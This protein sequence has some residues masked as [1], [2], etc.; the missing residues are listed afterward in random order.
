[1]EFNRNG[2]WALIATQFQGAFNDNAFKSFVMMIALQSTQDLNQRNL[3]S[4]LIPAVFILPFVI[5]SMHSGSVADRFSKRSVIVYTKL[6]EIF[7][8]VAGIGV[9]MTGNLHAAVA[10]M[11]FM[12]IQSAYFGPSKYGILPELVPEKYLSWA[13]GIMELTTFLAIIL[14]T[15]VGTVF[16][17]KLGAF[18]PVA[19]YILVSLSILGFI[20]S[21]RVPMVPA[22][23]PDKPLGYNPY[24]ELKQNL[25]IARKDRVLWL[26]MWGNG[27][28]WFL[29]GLLYSNIP[30]F[31]TAVLHLNNM[32][33]GSLLVALAMGIGIGS[34]AAGHLSGNK[35][36]YGLIPLGAIFISIFS[37]DLA[38]SVDSEWRA[39][40]ALMIL[41]L[42][43]G[44]FAVP[45]NALI[46][47]RPGHQEKGGI[48]GTAYFL[49]NVG[50]IASSAAFFLLT[51]VLKLSPTQVFLAGALITV[52][53]TAY[54][55]WLLPDALL[56]LLL[57]I[58]SHTLYRVQVV[59]RDN[60]PD[61]GGAMFVANHLSFLDALFVI[62]STDRFVRFIMAEE[63]YNQYWIYPFAR[64]MR[65][66]PIAGDSGL[67]A[68]LKSLR[69]ASQT[70][71]EGDIVCIFAEGQMT[72]TGQ[73]LPFRRGFE[74]IMK[75]VDAPIIPIHLDR[76]WGSIFSFE[77]G[78]YFWKWPRR[79]M[80][81]ITVSFGK[82]MPGNSSAVQVRR[83]IMELA[84]DAFQLRRQE[85]EPL[86]RAV[87]RELRRHF[88][89]FC[90]AD[91]SNPYVSCRAALIKAVVLAE[92]LQGVWA[93]QD[94]VGIWLPPSSAGACLNLAALLGGKVPVNLNFTAGP[95]SIQSAFEQC[96]LRTVVTSRLFL[97]RLKIT[98]PG[99][100]VLLE[101]LA[102]TV[103]AWDKVRAWLKSAFLPVSV[104]EWSLGST[105]N[106]VIDDLATVIF[107]SGS[108]GDPK[109]VMLS[110]YNV[111]SNLEATGQ[112]LA[113]TAQDR[114]M[115]VLPFFHSFGFT[116][117]L[118][119]PLIKGFGVVYHPNPM[120]SRVIGALVYRYGVTML[121]S[122]PTFLQAYMRRVQPEQFGSLNLVLVGAEKLTERVAIA[123]EEKFGIRPLEAYGCTE[124]SPA[125]SFNIRGFRGPGFYQVGAKRGR[126][127]H[128]LP[129]VSV[130]VV[131]PDT[132][133]VLPPNQPGLLLVKG[134]NVMMG[135]LGN[136]KKTQEVLQDGWYTTGDIAALDEEGFITITDRLSRFAKVGGE[137]VPL[138]R[139]EEMLHQLGGLNTQVFAVTA[140]PD[141][142]KGER[143]V[144]FY[145]LAEDR[146]KP[147]V[148]KLPGSGLPN[149]WLP[150][151]D[152]YIA[153]EALPV[154]GTGKL[155]LKAL[156][157]L[158]I[159]R[160][161]EKVGGTPSGETAG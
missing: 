117:T 39:R 79:V 67:R 126:I 23:A 6:L 143:L 152:G 17:E 133:E 88:G 154:L 4:A 83:S 124:C 148:E 102:E 74:K 10:V 81:P 16:I 150:R 112:V 21:F 78:R 86:H 33:T 22:A 47:H 149:L 51:Y 31:G 103:T 120:D 82:P 50:L 12:G 118:W 98:P 77:G 132:R 116:A 111:Y 44:F 108:T 105:K 121:V 20:L 45:I 160:M 56:R 101:D 87:V 66:I 62:G 158:A 69:D 153:V 122:T 113:V 2:F 89:Q 5:F 119:F 68:L 40:V 59:G 139:I 95:A 106:W 84:S 37:A 54:A 155:D 14:G 29:S 107:S 104:L 94:K 35:I 129:G 114:I 25:E 73:M 11:F 15:F 145:T 100:L 9:M 141:E 28:F 60:V 70:I 49:S 93:G 43:A 138:V 127:G 99:H 135:Y 147:I 97:E 72:R 91:G 32:D 144:V 131:D 52:V 136:E 34:Y 80:D 125:V 92:K 36:E 140:I 146:L 58:L 55:I 61:K 8:M 130:R 19:M 109:G 30:V 96:G 24:Q 157:E 7:I 142:K 26:S 115:G 1:M 46:Q 161:A 53:A 3:Y 156:K 18:S 85:M 137:M 71:R 110:H 63:Y 65:I 27:F 75:G 123:F 64:M 13:N 57:W 38:W 128:P 90:M 41:G 42:G 48:Q 76:I 159:K 151:S 134:P